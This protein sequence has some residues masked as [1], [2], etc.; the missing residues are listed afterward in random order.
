[1]TTPLLPFDVCES[2][3]RGNPASEAAN[4]SARHKRDLHE[5]ILRLLECGPM[6]SKEIGAHL[7]REMHVF[8]GRVSE[9]LA[10]GEIVATTYRRDGC[11]VLRLA[12]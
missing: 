9:L 1:M 10:T 11:R 5:Q 3:H 12:R 8:S 4:P 6:T 7:G 2:R